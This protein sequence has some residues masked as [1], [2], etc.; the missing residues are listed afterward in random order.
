LPGSV[1]IDF[2]EIEGED[3]DVKWHCMETDFN[4]ILI[5]FGIGDEE[6]FSIDHCGILIKYSLA[7]M[8]RYIDNHKN[9]VVDE[10]KMLEIYSGM[11]WG[12]FLDRKIFPHLV[13]GKNIFP[14]DRLAWLITY[15]EL[16][17]LPNKEFLDLWGNYKIDYKGYNIF[18]K[19][20]DYTPSELADL[21]K[22]EELFDAD[23]ICSDGIVKAHKT[24]L[25]IN[26]EML[27]TQLLRWSSENS[28]IEINYPKFLVKSVVDFLYF[29]DVELLRMSLQDTVELFQFTHLYFPILTDYVANELTRFEDVSYISEALSIYDNEHLK[30]YFTA[31]I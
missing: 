1:N 7:D 27:R 9:I 10:V 8:Y 26:S 21:Y 16:E 12:K 17:D 2:T 30:K 24:I 29:R 14:A 15:N 19:K 25:A 31:L 18:P 23:I 28:S 22:D 6:N 3:V 13:F 11:N 20:L 4:L 5:C